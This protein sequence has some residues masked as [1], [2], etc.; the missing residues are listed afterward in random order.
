MHATRTSSAV[1]DATERQI[2]DVR[3]GDPQQRQHGRAK[4]QQRRP[5]RPVE[6]FAK[7]G[8]CDREITVRLRVVFRAARQS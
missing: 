8:E 1:D 4:D 6:R 3:T 7:I 2:G 5:I